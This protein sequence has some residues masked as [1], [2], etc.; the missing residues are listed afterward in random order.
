MLQ[1]RLGRAGHSHTVVIGV[2]D[3]LGH[4]SLGEWVEVGVQVKPA[5]TEPGTAAQNFLLHCF[6]GFFFLLL[7]SFFKVWI[8]SCHSRFLNPAKLG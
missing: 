6:L 5:Y 1:H 4:P 3:E 2:L 7:F 8:P